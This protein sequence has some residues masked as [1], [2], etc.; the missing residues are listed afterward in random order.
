M[1]EYFDSVRKLALEY[2]SDGEYRRR[3]E[4]FFERLA[5]EGSA[6]SPMLGM[7]V[8]YNVWEGSVTEE[9]F[10]LVPL[11]EAE[12]REH[13]AYVRETYGPDEDWRTDLLA[14]HECICYPSTD[15]DVLCLGCGA[16]L[17]AIAAAPDW[18]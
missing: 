16:D 13:E 2:H 1:R 15:T 17:G 18:E 11:S 3:A 5:D 8:E 10:D 9:S 6:Y 4:R 14:E 12:K 7:M